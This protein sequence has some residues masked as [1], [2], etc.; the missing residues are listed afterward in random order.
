MNDY[1]Q[2][3]EDCKRGKPHKPG[4]SPAY[5]QG[6]ANQYEVEQRVTARTKRW[7]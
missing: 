6:Y 5:D 2:G 7:T 3:V 1:Q 4:K